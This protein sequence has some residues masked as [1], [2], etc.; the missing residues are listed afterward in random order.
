MKKFKVSIL[1]TVYNHQRYVYK[2]IKS[3]LNQSYN[4]FEFIIINNGSSDSSLDIIKKFKDKRI[5]IYNLKKNI[6]RTECLNFGLK[7]CKGKFIAIQDS[8]DVS[9]KNRILTQI[10]YLKKN[11]EISLVGSG[12]DIIDQKGK[13]LRTEKLKVDLST[14]PK[15]IVFKNIIG[16]STVMYKKDIIKFTRGYPSDF[17]YAQ[18]YAFYLK[19]ITKFKINLLE[20][21]LVSLRL[22]HPESESYRLKNS[23]RIQNEEMRL[24]FWT[25]K[26]IKT[27]F[28]DKIK[29]LKKL[30]ILITKIILIYL[31]LF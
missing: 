14:N 19:I 1:M 21:N 30:V 4:N 22:N 29:I 6:G 13:I 15:L 27:N 20:D 5:K 23:L 16:H 10:N 28:F 8:D 18:D 2:S 9:K 24:I 3:I 26:N 25:L 11:K 7:K 17:V 31:K 12:Y